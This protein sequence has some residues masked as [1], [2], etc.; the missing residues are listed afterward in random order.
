VDDFPVEDATAVSPV[1]GGVL[2][3]TGSYQP[4]L[5]RSVSGVSDYL[6]SDM[7]GT[8]RLTTG[9]TGA[10]SGS[11][12]FTAFGE[13]QAGSSERFGYVG[14]WGYEDTLDTT[15]AEVF[16]YLHLGARYYDPSSGRF[17]QRDPI[18]IR[19]GLNI[20]TYVGSRPTSA[21]DPFGLWRSE[22]RPDQKEIEKQ[23]EKDR[24]RPQSPKDIQK[25][26]D[27]VNNLIWWT[28]LALICTGG[29]LGGLIGGGAG[30]AIG[31]GIG[32]GAGSL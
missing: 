4:G 25:E 23:R 26:L 19:G 29:Y 21:A 18:G 16:P 8:L 27:D 6:H 1:D 17:L 7:L 3:N 30:G 14:A 5:W 9:T 15:G 32:A 31:A 22:L 2:S 10:A 12:V 24:A 20:Y 11:D 28:K 13:R